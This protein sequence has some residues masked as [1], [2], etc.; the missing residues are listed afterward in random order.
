M[1]IKSLTLALA[2][3]LMAAPVV[4]SANQ[5]DAFQ[6]ALGNSS[7]NYATKNSKLFDVISDGD[8]STLCDLATV[9]ALND[10]YVRVLGEY[11]YTP[12]TH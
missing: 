3:T 4:V 2:I 7:V 11:A 1:K 6:F 8:A 5:T 12:C 9:Y 10:I